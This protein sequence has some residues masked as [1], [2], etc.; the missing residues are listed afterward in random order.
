MPTQIADGGDTSG[1][2]ASV[3]DV[4]GTIDNELWLFSSGAPTTTTGPRP[5]R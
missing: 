3:P 5:T 1:N 4:I 2:G